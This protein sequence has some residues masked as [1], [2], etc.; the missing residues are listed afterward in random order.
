MGTGGFHSLDVMSGFPTFS[1]LKWAALRVLFSMRWPLLISQM[2]HFWHTAAI[3]KPNEM[4]DSVVQNALD[5]LQ[6]SIAELEQAPKYSVI[7]FCAAV[8]LFLKARLMLEHW[9]LILSRPD[10]AN[11]ADF[12]KGDF[13]SIG[14]D[15]A[16]S[17]LHK[18][19]G[20]QFTKQ[21]TECLRNLR[22]HRNKLIHFFNPDYAT[23]DSS[24]TIAEVVAEV[25]AEQC[26]AW[27]NLHD[28]LTKRWTKRFKDHAVAI[29]KIHRQMLKHRKFLD[30]KFETLK[31]DIEAQKREGATIVKCSACQFEAAEDVP[32]IGTS[33]CNSL[34]YL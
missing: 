13:K 14:I 24:Q 34:P 19:I 31:A 9:T 26:R 6:Q 29:Q 8:E 32:R 2:N 20:E 18:I 1:R 21:E 5:F 10:I 27:H 7:H 22:D 23:E 16:I 25:V 12:V 15:E 11:L 4:F 30:V 33:I 3:M 28:L 17:R